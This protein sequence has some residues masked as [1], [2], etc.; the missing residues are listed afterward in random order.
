[1]SD[2]S[3]RNFCSYG[4]VIAFQAQFNVPPV[5][6][7]QETLQLT[8]SQCHQGFSNKPLPLE[9]KGVVNVFCAQNCMDEFKRVCC[10]FKFFK[11]LN[12]IPLLNAYTKQ[13]DDF[14]VVQ[15]NIEGM[16]MLH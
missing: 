1:M 9:F 13:G 7:P 11:C 2:N 3:I 8:C 14:H 12:L 6:L 15:V 10:L 4:C 16:G 5:T